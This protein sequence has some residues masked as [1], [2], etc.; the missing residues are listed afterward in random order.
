MLVYRQIKVKVL[1]SNLTSVFLY[2]KLF[3]A[4]CTLPA[5]RDFSRLNRY[6]TFPLR[7]LGAWAFF[8][9]DCSA[10]WL[11]SA[12]CSE[13]SLSLLG[14]SPSQPHPGSPSTSLSIIVL[15]AAARKDC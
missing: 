8:P 7:L 15:S 4:V 14:V 6:H 1:K 2:C 3:L 13:Q 12:F 10:V 11:R 9:R 5:F